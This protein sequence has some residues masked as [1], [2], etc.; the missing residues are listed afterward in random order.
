MKTWRLLML[1]IGLAVFSCVTLQRAAAQDVPL[2][3][4]GTSSLQSSSEGSDGTVQTPEFDPAIDLSDDGTGSTVSS[5]S[6]QVVNRTLGGGPG[7]GVSVKSG[8]KA[9]SSP[10]VN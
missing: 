10:I 2:T 6:G 5:D 1:P 4:S 7:P 3:N 8:K 9:K